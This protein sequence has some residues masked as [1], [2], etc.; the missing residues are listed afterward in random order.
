MHHYS[1]KYQEINKRLTFHKKYIINPPNA[2]FK[3]LGYILKN[4]YFSSIYNIKNHYKNHKHYNAFI[5]YIK[6][7]IKLIER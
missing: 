5:L 1:N 3:R 4:T 2:L 7:P 6:R